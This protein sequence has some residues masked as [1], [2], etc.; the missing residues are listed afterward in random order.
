MKIP[1]PA[2]FWYVGL[3]GLADCA[4]AVP[5]GL[6][7]RAAFAAGGHDAALGWLFACAAILLWGWALCCCGWEL[8]LLHKR[9]VNP[10][11]SEVVSFALFCS[12]MTTLLLAL[13]I[14]VRI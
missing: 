12:G 14:T 7:S 9:R 2:E 11:A 1:Q 3:L 6:Y 13:G 8:L 4:V 5:V 10:A